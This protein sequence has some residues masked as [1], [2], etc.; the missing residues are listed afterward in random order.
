MT[1]TTATPTPVCA[2]GGNSTTE[3]YHDHECPL[4][5]V[6]RA[7]SALLA[8]LEECVRCIEYLPGAVYRVPVFLLDAADDARAAI[9]TARG[10]VTTTITPQEG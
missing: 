3:V 7:G 9:R 10:Q 8:A 4:Y 2:C 6:Q 5:R 1:T